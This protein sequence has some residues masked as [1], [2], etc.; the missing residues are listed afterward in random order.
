MVEDIR[1]AASELIRTGNVPRFFRE[2][3]NDYVFVS[4]QISRIP[5]G[6]KSETATYTLDSRCGLIFGYAPTVNLEDI[7]RLKRLWYFFAKGLISLQRLDTKFL[8]LNYGNSSSFDFDKPKFVCI[9]ENKPL[10]CIYKPLFTSPP[11]HALKRRDW[12]RCPLFIMQLLLCM[13]VENYRVY[14]GKLLLDKDEN[15]YECANQRL[16]C[17]LVFI[18]EIFS[19]VYDVRGVCFENTFTTRWDPEQK[20]MIGLGI[21]ESVAPPTMFEESQ[22][23]SDPPDSLEGW[24]NG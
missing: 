23:F 10:G 12:D 6:Q 8:V 20:S 22:I 2:T 13:F 4:R 3:E 16:G 17:A 19:Y 5:K 11:L 1:Q 7:L 9:S 18:H 24:K 21:I 15:V 14:W